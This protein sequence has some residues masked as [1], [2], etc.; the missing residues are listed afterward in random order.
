MIKIKRAKLAL[1]YCAYLFTFLLFKNKMKNFKLTWKPDMPDFRDVPYVAPK[2]VIPASINLATTYSNVYDQQ[3]L[4][5]CTGNAIAMGI[6]FTLIKEGK[7]P[8]NGSRLFIYYNERVIEGTVK[9]DAGAQIRDGIKTVYNSGLC[10]EVLWPYNQNKYQ[11]KPSL[12]CY[13]TA[14]S[15]LLTKYMRLDNS[16]LSD[17]KSCLAEGYG[18]VFGFSVYESFETEE[19]AT[20][21]I[22]PMPAT[23]ETILGGHAVFCVGFDD[24]TQ[25]FKV[26]NSWGVGWGDKG[27]F[28]IPYSYLTNLNLAD[29][30]WTM[31]TVL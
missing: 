8:L 28:Y 26:R 22:V 21:G 13:T 24:K 14:K 27:H 12:K 31:R 23:T 4:G 11:V 9:Q 5:S 2:I 6:D 10:S 20:T 25:S 19:V 18:F 7:K 29:D 16:K 1:F 3:N 17:L 15:N 30:F